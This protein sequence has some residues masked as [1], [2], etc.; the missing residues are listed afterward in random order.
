MHTT[1]SGTAED[2]A[3]NDSPPGNSVVGADGDECGEQDDDGDEEGHG[4][5]STRIGDLH[6]GF[7][8]G[9]IDGSVTDEV[10]RRGIMCERLSAYVS[11]SLVAIVILVYLPYTR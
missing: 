6:L 4:R 5:E 3:E 8:V 7:T 11:M 10:L 1:Y 9:K 2:A